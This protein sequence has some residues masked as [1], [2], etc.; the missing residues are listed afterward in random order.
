MSHARL[1]HANVDL[2]LQ[3]AAP[4]GAGAVAPSGPPTTRKVQRVI[5]AMRDR[6]EEGLPLRSMA[7]LAIQSPFHFI[8]KFH[9]VTG[10]TPRQFMGALRVD[11]ARRLLLTTRAS[12][13]DVCFRVGYNSL[14]T[15][16]TR[17]TQLVGLAPRD[18]RRLA[19]D[20][21]VTRLGDLPQSEELIPFRGR[22][23]SIAGRITA[24]DGF[25]GL[26]FI[27]LFPTPVPQGAPLS[28]ALLSG[29][30]PYAVPWP[31]ADGTYYVMA[32]AVENLDDPLPLLLG[33]TRL[34]GRSAPLVVSGGHV[35]GSADIALRGP[36]LTDP[37][38]LVS[39][40]GLLRRIKSPA[41]RVA[42]RPSHAAQ[43]HDEARTRRRAR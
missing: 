15:F 7:L 34:R 9:L 24:P 12:V 27:G 11:A 8:R 21:D 13:T 18:L 16:T 42:S 40:P 2:D 17:F 36:L 6:L 41:R 5:L 39:L 35:T 4:F 26:I 30:G 32:T 22:S 19:S 33:D 14:G 10:I 20:A 29:S 31:S 37:P 23:L 28:C 1:P 38:I 25:T 43:S 3:T